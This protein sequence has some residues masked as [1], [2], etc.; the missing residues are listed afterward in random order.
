MIGG[1]LK[2]NKIAQFKNNPAT[3]SDL[4]VL[5]R[6]NE[7]YEEQIFINPSSFVSDKDIQDDHVPFIEKKKYALNLI[8]YKFPKNHHT[9]EDKYENVNWKYVEIFYRVFFDFLKQ[10]DY[11]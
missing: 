5:S 2:E 3:S 4:E 9:L 7:K 11:Y 1:D 10:I 8:P 6:L